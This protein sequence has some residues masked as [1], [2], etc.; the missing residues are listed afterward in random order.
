MIDLTAHDHLESLDGVLDRHRGARHTGELLPGVGVLRQELLDT[1][2]PSDDDLV[3]LAQLVDTEDGDD[4][5]QLLVALQDLLHLGGRL[6][7]LLAHVLRVEDARGGGERV[8]GRVQTA[9]GNGT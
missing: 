7:V 9:R 5:L 1:A 4:V 8:H 3:L 2:C 6:V